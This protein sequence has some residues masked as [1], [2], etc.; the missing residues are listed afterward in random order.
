MPYAQPSVDQVLLFLILHCK[1]GSRE[2]LDTKHCLGY[3][4]SYTETSKISGQSGIEIKI[5]TYLHI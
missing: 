5:R 4:I 2:V 1:T 3:C